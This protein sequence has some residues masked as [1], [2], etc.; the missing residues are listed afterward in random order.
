M[1]WHN[2]DKVKYY[3]WKDRLPYGKYK[4]KKIKKVAIFDPTYI[5][6]LHK[7]TITFRLNKKTYQKVLTSAVLR[8][9]F[10]L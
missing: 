1:Q 2:L 3:D 4:G 8:D 10:V 5:I 6:W 9:L 7:N